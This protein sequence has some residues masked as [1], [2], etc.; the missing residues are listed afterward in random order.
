MSLPLNL[1]LEQL[2]SRWKSEIDPVLANLLVQ[3]RILQ[4]VPLVTGDNTINHGLGRKLIG[5]VL[6][7]KSATADIYSKQSTNPSP[8]LSLILS[9]P[10]PAT[11]SLWVF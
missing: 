4:N 6:V 9:S 8:Q 2:Q 3:G 10:A 7:D 1:P 5:W 11:V